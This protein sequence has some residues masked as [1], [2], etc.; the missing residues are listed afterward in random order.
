MPER[1]VLPYDARL[2]SVQGALIEPATAALHAL[3]CLDFVGGQD[4]AVFGARTADTLL[5]QW[6]RLFGARRACG[7]DIDQGIFAWQPLAA[8]HAQISQPSTP[9]IVQLT[10]AP[11]GQIWYR[12]NVAPT[13]SR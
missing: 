10:N 13:V 9:G 4:V 8:T 6:T 1:N 11:S 2:I 5:V 7:F 3:R 12:R